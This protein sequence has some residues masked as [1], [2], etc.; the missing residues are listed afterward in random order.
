[1]IHVFLISGLRLGELHS[2]TLGQVRL[3]AETPHIELRA[4]DEK[5][6]RGPWFHCQ[7]IWRLT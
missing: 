5:A 2:I 7:R 6:R 4:T 3:D 1:M